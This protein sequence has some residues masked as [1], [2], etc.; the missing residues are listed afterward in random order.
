MDY[1]ELFSLLGEI[2]K[3]GGIFSLLSVMIFIIALVIIYESIKTFILSGKFPSFKKKKYNLGNHVIFERLSS[4]IDYQIGNLKINCP[5]RDKVFKR[6]LVLRFEIMKE[7]FEEE[8]KKNCNNISQEQLC[9]IWKTFLAKLE[10][11]W[12]EKIK[13]IG[14]PPIVIIKF[15]ELRESITKAIDELTN[16]LCVRSGDTEETVSFIFDII[17]SLET[18]SL[19]TAGAAINSLNGE[20]S[21]IEF[22]GIKC[23]KCN[24]GK[25][26]FKSGG[27]DVI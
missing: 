16:N 5:L 20:L 13:A 10:S 8:A 25:C 2:Y 11:E 23:M 19:F 24:G 18:S 4:I 22:E 3:T 17:V 9:V 1:K 12:C 27:G 6:I 15:Y 26:K 14:T 7:L 21:N